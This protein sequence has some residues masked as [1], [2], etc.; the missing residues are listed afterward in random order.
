MTKI[1]T[2]KCDSRYDEAVAEVAEFCNE[3]GYRVTSTVASPAYGTRETL[4]YKLPRVTFVCE[5]KE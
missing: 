5:K 3:E 2:I 4:E 1:F